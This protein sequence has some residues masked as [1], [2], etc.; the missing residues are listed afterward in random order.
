VEDWNT[1]EGDPEDREVEEALR[2]A[3]AEAWR[4][5]FEV[6]H[7]YLAQSEHVAWEGG[8]ELGTTVGEER[9]VVQMPYA[10]YSQDVDRIVALLYEIGAV[11]PFDWPRWEGIERY[12]GPSALGPAPLADAARMAT[13][14]VRGDRFCEG[15]LGAAIEDGTFGAILER[16]LR[17]YDSERD[18]SV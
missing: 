3:P 16:L 8:Q 15:L 13:A 17:C 1:V 11:F 14:I 2:R 6:A 7:R 9:P 10:V 4:E 5:L 12:R 18:G